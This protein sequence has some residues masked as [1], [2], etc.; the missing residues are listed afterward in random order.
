[1]LDHHLIYVR[2]VSVFR[3]LSRLSSLPF[4]SI[5]ST[6][7]RKDPSSLLLF[8]L[9][10]IFPGR[11]N[12]EE[13]RRSRSS[14]LDPRGKVFLLSCTRAVTTLIRAALSSSGRGTLEVTRKIPPPPLLTSGP[15][16][17]HNEG[18]CCIRLMEIFHSSEW[19][20]SSPGMEIEEG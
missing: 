1:M 19:V 6:S 2:N 4:N 20:R 12:R 5:N 9:I 10:R 17:R 15:F 11:E 7:R 13:G 3:S 16:A 18:H 14:A 8:V